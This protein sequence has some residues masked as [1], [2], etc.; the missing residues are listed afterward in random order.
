MTAWIGVRREDKS[1]WERR[2]PI[3]PDVAWFIGANIYPTFDHIVDPRIGMRY[4]YGN[5]VI[6]DAGYPESRLRLA[7]DSVRFSLAARWALWP[8][9]KLGE[10]D[11]RERLRYDELRVDA[12]LEFSVTAATSLWLQGGGLF[13]REIAFESAANAVE[14]ENAL[15]MGIGLNRIL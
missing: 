12:T 11:V 8:E 5:E 6:V 13:Q 10:D 7:G 2:V 4:A 1:Q 15:F 3:T 14:I 9:Y